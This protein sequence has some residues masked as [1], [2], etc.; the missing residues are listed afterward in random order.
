MPL[1]NRSALAI[2][3]FQVNG[4]GCEALLDNQASANFMTL[5]FARDHD[6]EHHGHGRM[7]EM[8]SGYRVKSLGQATA[9]IQLHSE[10]AI[11]WE[12][13]VLES[14]MEPLILGRRFLYETKLLTR[15]AQ[16]LNDN[17]QNP[18]L[19]KLGIQLGPRLENVCALPIQ[20]SPRDAMSDTYATSQNLPREAGEYII[21]SGDGTFTH[22]FEIVK[23]KVR[24]NNAGTQDMLTLKFL[25]IGCL[26]FDL[27]LGNTTIKQRSL[28]HPSEKYRPWTFPSHEEGCFYSFNVCK[29]RG[30]GLVIR[31]IDLL[32]PKTAKI[33]R[34]PYQE[35]D[36]P[37]D[38]RD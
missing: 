37:D 30:N 31:V 10:E 11:P 36:P 7:F 35:P 24:L 18:A 19:S 1:F 4:N 5:G 22:S 2:Y 3:P 17:G 16:L 6:I 8:V 21:Q 15:P 29:K 12:F 20:S 28:L 9:N 13:E 25:V 26:P 38:G 27:T 33:V 23:T 34:I 32:K 14:A